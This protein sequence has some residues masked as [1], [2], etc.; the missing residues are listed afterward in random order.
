MCELCC[1]VFCPFIHP[2]LPARLIPSH[3]LV[4]HHLVALLLKWGL[5]MWKQLRQEQRGHTHSSD[6]SRS[7]LRVFL[8]DFPHH[9]SCSG[10]V[11]SLP[12]AA[13]QMLLLQL[14]A[15][16]QLAA[17]LLAF[18]SWL[19][20]STIIPVLPAAFLLELPDDCCAEICMTQDLAQ[21]SC[22]CSGRM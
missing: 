15:V 20:R 7:V 22:C 9:L 5:T 1:V 21:P 11:P 17:S 18:L 19:H 8:D 13:L 10:R 12:N 16:L 3:W 14:A 2:V 6:C 4:T